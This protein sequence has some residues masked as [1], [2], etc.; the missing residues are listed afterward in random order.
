M[1]LVLLGIMLTVTGLI[2]SCFYLN[3]NED[4]DLIFRKYYMRAIASALSCREVAMARLTNNFLYRSGDV[5]V[6]SASPAIINRL[7]EINT[8]ISQSNLLPLQNI[9][10]KFSISDA[11]P[12]YVQDLLTKV[13]GQVF[14]PKDVYVHIETTGTITLPKFINLDPIIVRLSSLASISYKGPLILYTQLFY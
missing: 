9:D 11:D 5:S 4:R 13:D 10:C 8:I 6:A 7:D 3:A 1:I 2:Y 14:N 12:S